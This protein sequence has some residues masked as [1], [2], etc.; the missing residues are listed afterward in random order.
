V[1]YLPAAGFDGVAVYPPVP[2]SNIQE[3]SRILERLDRTLANIEAYI[4]IAYAVLRKEDIVQRLFNLV[5][6]LVS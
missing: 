5:S 3:Y 6:P 1:F 2:N 4:H